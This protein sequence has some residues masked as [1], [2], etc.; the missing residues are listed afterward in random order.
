[1]GSFPRYYKIIKNQKMSG[2]D[3]FID[4]ISEIFR[5][6]IPSNAAIFERDAVQ[7]DEQKTPTAPLLET[8]VAAPD[9]R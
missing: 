3:E 9:A 7:D 1:M 4:G 6:E 5:K 8:P 2:K